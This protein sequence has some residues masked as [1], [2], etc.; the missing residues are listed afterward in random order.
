VS[1]ER[2]AGDRPV[3][4]TELLPGDRMKVVV[5]LRRPKRRIFEATVPY[6]CEPEELAALVIDVQ[7]IIRRRR[8]ARQQ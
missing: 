2:S 7:E 4:H 6:D 8:K 1:R 5:E 3:I